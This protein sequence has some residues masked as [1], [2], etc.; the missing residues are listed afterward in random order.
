MDMRLVALSFLVVCVF[1]GTAGAF[2][3]Q[4]GATYTNQ[5]ITITNWTDKP[6]ECHPV[7][8]PEPNPPNTLFILKID[9][10]PAAVGGVEVEDENSTQD[11]GRTAI[12]VNDPRDPPATNV[13][14]DG[15][16]KGNGRT[17]DKVNGISIG[18]P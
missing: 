11:N 16:G 7:P 3:V 1:V 2:T 5:G 9:V 6:I 10:D 17:C 13:D 4:P 12:D 15:L 14:G 18:S 8:D